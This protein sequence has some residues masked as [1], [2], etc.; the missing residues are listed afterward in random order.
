LEQLRQRVFESP[1]VAVAVFVAT[2]Y[3]AGLPTI[4]TVLTAGLNPADGEAAGWRSPAPELFGVWI[5]CALAVGAAA[6]LKDSEL[7][8]LL[9]L[10]RR[11]SLTP[12]QRRREAVLRV[13]TLLLEHD[14][15]A[16]ALRSFESKI[17]IPSSPESPTELVPFLSADIKTWERWPLGTG[18]V[19]VTFKTNSDDV[20]VFRGA[21]LAKLNQALTGEQLERYKH[22]TMIAA[23]VIRDDMNE[24]LGVLSVSSAARSPRFD[25]SRL[26]A[27]KLLAGNLGVFLEVAV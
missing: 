17:F 9:D 2:I 21:Y 11:R 10:L 27:M 18:A 22:L 1:I 19:G 26:R 4:Y 20:L 13:I 3:L 25:Q 8:S 24:P 16:Q 12:S 5:V 15:D 14:E 23:I 6:F 7:Q